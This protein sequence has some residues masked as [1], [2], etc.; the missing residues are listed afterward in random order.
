MVG[1]KFTGETRLL[2]CSLS[3]LAHT[4]GLDD[5]LY[6]VTLVHVGQGIFVWRRL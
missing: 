5:L 2:N 4:E 6:N 3:N 1:D